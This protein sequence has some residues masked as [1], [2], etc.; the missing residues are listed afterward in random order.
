MEHVPESSPS[1]W[2]Y[3]AVANPDDCWPY[4]RGVDRGGYGVDPKAIRMGVKSNLA[5]A[6]THT[7]NGLKPQPVWTASTFAASFVAEPT[8]AT[9]FKAN[10]SIEQ[11]FERQFA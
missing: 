9:V 3:V 5:W 7:F 6:K 1:F 4:Q 10:R 2:R 11:T 8:E